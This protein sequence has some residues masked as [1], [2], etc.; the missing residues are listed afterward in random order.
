MKSAFVPL[1][2]LAV[3]ASAYAQSA[4]KPVGLQIHVGFGF[5]PSFQADGDSE[6]MRGPEIGVAIPVGTFAGN[7]ILLEPSFFGGGRLSHGTDFDSDVYR[8][9][10][11]AHRTFAQGIG[12]RIG[13]GYSNSARARGHHINGK[14]D[15]IFDLGLEL[16]FRSHLLQTVAPYVD[17]HGVAAA[18]HN[19]LSGFFVGL[20]VKI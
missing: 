12:A 4:P 6:T 14:S 15:V 17:I 18:Q 3:A 7:G 10:L 13:V 11:F 1:V 16:P 20:G 8:L 19:I 5:T 9:T 2:L